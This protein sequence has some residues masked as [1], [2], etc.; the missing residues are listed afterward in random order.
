[1]L[2]RLFFWVA[3]FG[4]LAS[5]PSVAL[6]QFLPPS[7]PHAFAGRAIVDGDTAQEGTPI[8]AWSGA[9]LLAKTT[10]SAGHYSLLVPERSNGQGISFN[11]GSVA[12]SQVANWL[13]GGASFLDLT[14]TTHSPLQALPHVFTGRALVDDAP[15]KEGTPVTA[16]SGWGLLA[17][18]TVVQGR[19]TLLVSR[20]ATSPSLYFNLGEFKS[21]ETSSWEPGGATLL[22]LTTQSSWT[23]LDSVLDPRQGNLVRVFHR[24]PKNG[25]WSY[26]DPLINPEDAAE[27]RL[28]P[29]EEY[30]IR[31]MWD[32]WVSHH[33]RQTPLV[34]GWNVVVW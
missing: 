14:A 17:R 19:Y 5:L 8:T 34:S 20:P 11:I 4:L 22:D 24:N 25:N 16:W 1:M 6:G 30:W 3:A 31:V 2:A 23:S 7:P 29:G 18:A 10:L 21:F 15:A 32:Q 33:N 27:F 12:A 13:P 28:R 9:V 26:F